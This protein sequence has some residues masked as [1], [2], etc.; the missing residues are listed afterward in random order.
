MPEPEGAPAEAVEIDELSDKEVAQQA[1]KINDITLDVD[2]RKLAG[3]GLNTVEAARTFGEQVAVPLS[4]RSPL[5]GVAPDGLSAA[6]AAVA[7]GGS[8][9]APAKGAFGELEYLRDQLNTRVKELT[10]IVGQMGKSL[11]SYGD[12]AL[13]AFDRY[14]AND[15]HA[16][17]ELSAT[18]QKLM[19]SRLTDPDNQASRPTFPG[20][21]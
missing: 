15:R 13:D 8:M 9:S 19:N 10:G 5:A 18:D 17:R 6:I 14:D 3:F 21:S 20:P 12:A 11:K 7:G 2:L 4:N 1:G 16:H